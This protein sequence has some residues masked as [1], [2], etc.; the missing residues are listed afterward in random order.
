MFGT[1]IRAKQRDRA[2]EISYFVCNGGCCDTVADH[3]LPQ[4]LL[5]PVPHLLGRID[6]N[7]RQAGAGGS[8]IR[9]EPD[10]RLEDLSVVSTPLA[11]GSCPKMLGSA[12]EGEG[13][14]QQRYVIRYIPAPKRTVA[15]DRKL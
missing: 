10:L 3:E 13:V 2:A 1:D 5:L 7:G 4:P 15:C 14:A 11:L 8:Q 12:A 6:R 9:G